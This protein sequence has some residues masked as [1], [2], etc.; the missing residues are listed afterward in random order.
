MVDELA[1]FITWTCYGTHLPGDERGWTKWR[2]GD[3][4]AQ[5]LLEEWCRE[6][7]NEAAVLLDDTQREIVN[8]A[9]RDHC[10]HQ[11]WELRAVNCRSN[12]CHVVAAAGVVDGEPVRD[13]LKAWA[14]RR[15]REHERANLAPDEEVRQRWWTRR[16]S[17]H[18]IFDEESLDA[19][20]I[21]TLEAQDHGGSKNM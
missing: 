2:K 18:K 7:M 1:L 17:V 13:Q 6:R 8:Q 21:Y 5:P 12:H 19:A 10:E 20:A 16:G 15:L 3:R 14:T 9:V 11:G 4:V